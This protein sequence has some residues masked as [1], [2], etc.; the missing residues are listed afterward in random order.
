VDN[1][2]ICAGT[3]LHVFS[4][5]QAQKFH[6]EVFEGQVQDASWRGSLC[7]LC[8]IAAIGKAYDNTSSA[9][10]SSKLYY[11]VSKSLFEDLIEVRSLDGIKV[12]TLLALFN[13]FDKATL[14]IIHVGMSLAS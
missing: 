1:F 10:G 3:L 13:I 12:C 4:R 11:D 7:C 5:E 2:F 6:Q 8:A 9:S 14:A